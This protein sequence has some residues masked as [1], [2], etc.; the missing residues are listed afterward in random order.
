MKLPWSKKYTKNLND[1]T[2]AREKRLD[3]V[4]DLLYNIR[5]EGK[6]RKMNY[7]E[8]G[9]YDIR[10]EVKKS[11]E[12]ASSML[13][14]PFKL[15]DQ[16]NH[17]Y[18]TDAFVAGGAIRDMLLGLHPRDVDIF[19]PISTD[20]DKDDEAVYFSELF[21]K[22]AE[23]IG[24]N[25]THAEKVG[26]EGYRDSPFTAYT[27]DLEER[28]RAISNQVIAHEGTP[29]EI[30]NG[31]DYDLVRAF[32]RKGRFY[33]VDTFPEIIKKGSIKVDTLAAKSRLN[34]WKNRTG[35]R[36][37]VS[38]REKVKPPE[39]K[40]TVYPGGTATATQYL[41]VNNWVRQDFEAAIQRDREFMAGVQWVN[42]GENN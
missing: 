6:D 8:V 34:A 30:V 2:S 31:F 38:C 15:V 28:W 35:Y 1:V 7:I 36:L 37:S 20:D 18:G 33:V 21:R 25:Y 12:T 16:I 4:D 41:K 24:L 10:P 14:V 39:F 3:K 17:K 23:G 11:I 26:G 29:E 32:Y 42:L 27:L 13:D 40:T 9:P 5:T 22:E 19:L